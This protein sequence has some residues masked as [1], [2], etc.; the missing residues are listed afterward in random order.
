MNESS[1]WST[2]W[3]GMVW[4]CLGSLESNGMNIWHGLGGWRAVVG[5]P[6]DP[7]VNRKCEWCM[8]DPR[9][10]KDKWLHEKSEELNIP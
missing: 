8:Q 4:L 7:R 3:G 2:Q 1:F 10:M 5:M 9:S 6:C